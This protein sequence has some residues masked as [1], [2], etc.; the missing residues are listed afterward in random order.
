MSVETATILSGGASLLLG[1]GAVV[2]RACGYTQVAWGWA[3][4]A[5][6]GAMNF[7][8]LVVNDG[9]PVV[10]M[11]AAYADSVHHLATPA[12]RL[13]ALWDR[14]PVP[15]GIASP[16]D[17]L[18]WLGMVVVFVWIFRTLLGA[19]KRDVARY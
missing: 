17:V 6:G 3:I 16:G 18:L 12:D 9:M 15:G 19:K 13:P 5:L 1:V 14:I 4:M 2:A 7:T 8:A 11:P 10:G